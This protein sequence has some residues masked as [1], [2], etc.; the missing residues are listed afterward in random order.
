MTSDLKNLIHTEKILAHYE[1]PLTDK[2]LNNSVSTIIRNF[3]KISTQLNILLQDTD[4]SDINRILED[5]KSITQSSQH[6]INE[7]NDPAFIQAIKTIAANMSD[8]SQT[9][10]DILSQNNSTN[11]NHILQNMSE[12]TDDINIL[13]GEHR[14]NRPH[15]LSTISSLSLGNQTAVYQNSDTSSGYFDSLFE[16]GLGKYSLISGVGN[17]SGETKMEHFQQAYYMTPQLRSRVGV[18]YNEAGV[19]VDYHLT[20][21]FLVGANYYNFANGYYNVLGSL[22]VYPHINIQMIYRNFHDNDETGV[23]WGIRYDL[24]IIP[25]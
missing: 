25:K 15:I 16:I 5:I 12:I 6:F 21:R 24:K 1:T 22:L 14:D 7:L 8:V 11:I 19:G 20:Q 17:K 10:K 13:L 23:D 18:I 9:S 3:E 2:S 4:E